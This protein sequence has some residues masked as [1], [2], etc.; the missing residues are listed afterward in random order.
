M[1]HSFNERKTCEA[2]ND[3]TK[4]KK[5]KQKRE[6]KRECRHRG[7]KQFLAS[8]T[9]RS[10][11]FLIQRSLRVFETAAQ[12]ATSLCELFKILSHFISC[13]R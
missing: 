4:K 1:F 8:H 6:N 11:K 9:F 5:T 12:A 10:F 3:A 7:K 13:C 2:A